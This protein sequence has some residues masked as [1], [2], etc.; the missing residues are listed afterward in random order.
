[1]LTRLKASKKLKEEADLKEVQTNINLIKPKPGT[2]R[3]VI[4]SM[5]VG[6]IGLF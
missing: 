3:F 2:E 5:V 4:H 1:M 6:Y